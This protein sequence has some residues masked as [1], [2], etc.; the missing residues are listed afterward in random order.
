[1]AEFELEDTA[2]TPNGHSPVNGVASA[3]RQVTLATHPASPARQAI[4]TE[5]GVLAQYSAEIDTYYAGMNAFEG[6]EPDEVMAHIAAM[7]ARLTEVRAR[8]HRLG[9]T[10][11]SQLRTREVDPML[12]SLK[13]LF[14][15]YSRLLASR[16]FDYE[17]SRGGT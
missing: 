6:L 14:Q 10:R 13:L 17:V 7:V 12:D 16:Q 8:L 15:I 5:Q 1:M 11:A 3:R 4:S 2:A 9:T